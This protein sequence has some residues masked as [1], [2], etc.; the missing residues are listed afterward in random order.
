MRQCLLL[1]AFLALIVPA[2]AAA[3]Q[4]ATPVGTPAGEC[5]A[6][7]TFPVPAGDGPHDVAPAANGK[8]IWYTGQTAGVLGV[9]DPVTG[10]VQH[11]ELGAGSAPHG[12][13][14]GPDDAAWVTDSGLN[15][16]V[17]V[18]AETREVQMFPLPPE[19]TGA[20]LNTAAFDGD[21]TLWFTGQNGVIG[22]V[23]PVSGKVTVAPSPRGRGPYGITA[24]PDGA[25]WF[26]SLAGDYL[27]QIAV[28]AITGAITADEIDP[29]TTGAG[30]RRVWSDSEGALWISEWNAGQVGR[31]DPAT[32]TWK[33][34]PLPGED[35]HAYAV[36]VDTQ[37]D[38]WL[39][40]F[41][42][43]ALV[44][45]DPGTETFTVV[46]LPDPGAAVRQLNGRAGEVWGAESAVD[47]LVVVRTACLDG[48]R[49]TPSS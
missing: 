38:I 7:E 36:F 10:E 37:D 5:R 39:S 34:W 2:H 49:A 6:V 19:A 47:K 20:N 32:K 33:E 25:V 29:P 13:V 40:D 3:R 30:P 14:V 1:L 46:A 24:T 35:P 11:V 41:G 45:F 17:R 44:R 12:V 18:D 22:S 27:G 23:D 15:A 42:G 9:L 4:P 31:Y 8:G 21:G 28:E 48:G 26:A 16:I 43:N